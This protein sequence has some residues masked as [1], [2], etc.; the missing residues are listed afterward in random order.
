MKKIIEDIELCRFNGVD[1]V[2]VYVGGI[3]NLTIADLKWRKV[4][5]LYFGDV[6]VLRLSEIVEQLKSKTTLIT[7]FINEPLKG[8][9]LQY[10][11]YGDEWWEIGTTC[12]YA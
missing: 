5:E 6:E 2:T 3:N 7:V 10:G 4:Y 1:V 9:I 8:I 11:N 12:G